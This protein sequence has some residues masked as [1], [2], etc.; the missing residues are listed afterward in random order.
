MKRIHL[1]LFSSGFAWLC[2]AQTSDL[3]NIIDYTGKV[4]YGYQAKENRDIDIIVIHSSYYVNPDSF[5]VS[6]VMK[7]Y[8]QYGVS[9]HYIIDRE[10]NIYLTVA[11][12]NI[13]FHAGSGKLPG[14]DRTAINANSIGI[15]IL[16]TPTNPPTEAELNALVSLVKD[17]K[18]RHPIEHLV[19]HSD[20]APNRKTDPWA[21][22]WEQ[23]LQMAD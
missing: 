15:E 3:P 16:T 6:G 18:A 12:K 17:I 8:K 23:F 1:I 2:N 5:L 21:F 19:R 4:N 22:P 7:Q 11:E 13:A 20:I 14:T 10:G 9:P